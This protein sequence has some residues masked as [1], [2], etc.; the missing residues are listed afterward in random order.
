MSD[1]FIFQIEMECPQCGGRE[2][3]NGRVG[4][5][6]NYNCP[7]CHG[8]GTITKTMKLVVEIDGHMVRP[9]T[10]EDLV[11]A[12]KELIENKAHRTGERLIADIKLSDGRTIKTV[13]V[14]K[15]EH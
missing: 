6:L 10:V 13:E 9:A 14:M 3:W 7:T 12:V 11:Q 2:G 8:F 5:N 15:N 4:N 1:P